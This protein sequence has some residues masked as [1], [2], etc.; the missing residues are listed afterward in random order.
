MLRGLWNFLD[1]SDIPAELLLPS[2][3]FA[4]QHGIEATAALF[5]SI[6]N[7][8]VGGIEEVLK[9]HVMF[10][11]GGVITREFLN[12]SLFQPDGFSNSELCN[13]AYQYSKLTFCWRVRYSTQIEAKMESKRWS[14]KLV[15]TKS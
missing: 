11:T 12:S 7:V 9:H 10:V 2:R 5:T 6:S 13:R 1:G 3:E 14:R 8:G 4:K 15:A